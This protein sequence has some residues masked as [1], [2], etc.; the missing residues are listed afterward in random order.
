MRPLTKLRPKPAENRELSWEIPEPPAN[1][2]PNGSYP[3]TASSRAQ[4][5]AENLSVLA[6]EESPEETRARLAERE[7]APEGNEEINVSPRS[8]P[9]PALVV[10]SASW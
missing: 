2:T 4:E 10:R 6:V 9:S 1:R 8:A 7:A 3:G 5:A